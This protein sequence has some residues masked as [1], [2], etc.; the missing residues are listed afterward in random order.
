MIDV[1]K[2]NDKILP[3]ID[4]N[5]VNEFICKHIKLIPDIKVIKV[6]NIIQSY[7]IHSPEINT[8]IN[9]LLNCLN[10][11]DQK[12]NFVNNKM[13]SLINN[14]SFLYISTKYEFKETQQIYKNIKE[15]KINYRCASLYT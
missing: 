8:K 6:K 10:T 11:N 4:I 1:I 2:N 5:S 14:S 13:K 7:F 9:E 3:N 15:W 12:F